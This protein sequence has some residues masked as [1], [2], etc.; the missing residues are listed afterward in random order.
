MDETE[1]ATEDIVVAR[2]NTVNEIS[3]LAE[4]KNCDLIVMGYYV[5]GKIGEA[6][7]GS[8]VR[9]VLR[10]SKIPVLLVRLSEKKDLMPT[11]F[12]GATDFLLDRFDP[13]EYIDTVERGKVTHVML[14]P[15]QIIALLDAPNFT[16]EKLKSLE[17]ILSLGAPF[18]RNTKM[19]LPVP[20]LID[21]MSFMD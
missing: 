4:G 7:L 10:R 8:T 16:Y 5:R 13:V 12:V 6:F 11:I 15:A 9:K 2:D 19:R 17:M 14:V 21:F 3:F 1:I 18:S 20:C